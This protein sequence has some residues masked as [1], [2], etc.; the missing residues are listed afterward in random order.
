MSEDQIT[1]P[2]GDP[3]GREDDWPGRL[4]RMLSARTHVGRGEWGQAML[5]E[6]DEVAESRARWRFAAGSA[7]AMV[8]PFL[9]SQLGLIALAIA[10][11][12]AIVAH[13]A[14]PQPGLVAA[15]AMPDVLCLCAWA[16]AAEPTARPGLS[17]VSRVGQVIAIAA[18]AACPVLG[19]L[20]LTLYPGQAGTGEA[21]WAFPAMVI[22]FAAELA[23]YVLLVLRR[24]DPLGAWR[25][26]GIP[27]LA[28]AVAVGAVFL[29]NN[30]PP[31][32]E[33]GNPIVNSAVMITAIV[34]P[35]A[36]GV[37]AALLDR[38]GRG[39]APRLRS[40]AGEALWGWLLCAPAVFIAMMLATSRA[41]ITAE[42]AQPWIGYEAQQHGATSVL[43]WVSGD[44]A[45][46]AV[47]LFTAIST[48][49]LLIFLVVHALSTALRRLAAARRRPQMPAVASGA[50][51]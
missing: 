31:G 2:G 40:G 5:A 39:I 17:M 51:H 12:G 35:L 14:D 21:P 1:G 30:R 29:L 26:S 16:A 8:I 32:G 18:V 48:A 20:L 43:A 33:S 25:Y 10:V 37:L 45:G 36:A 24:P 9:A 7:R 3:S 6:L 28:A 4:L 23:T 49:S 27:G 41:A 15:F 38:S 22:T 19:F 42:A 11:A 44:D 47:M 34:F 50:Q 46:G 13:F